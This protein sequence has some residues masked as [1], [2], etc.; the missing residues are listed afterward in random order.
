MWKTHWGLEK[1]PF[2][3][4]DAL[5]VSLPAHD[6]AVARLIHSIETQER[7]AFLTAGAGLGKSTVLRR[8]F[9]ETQSPR[10]RFVLA[11][12][13]RDGTVLFAHLAERFAERVGREPSRLA[14]WRALERAIRLASIQGTHVILGIDDCQLADSDGRRDLEA[15]TRMGSGQNTRLTV[16]Q[17][18]RRTRGNRDDRWAVAIGLE[19]LT[20][21][22]A[23]AFLATKLAGAGCR[24]SPFTPRAVT[25]LHC[26]GAGV[27]RRLQQLATRCLMVGAS[28][29]LL[30]IRP[31]LVDGLAEEISGQAP[32]ALGAA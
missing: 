11:S 28:R 18:G 20:R 19:S 21:S 13:P 30:V 7:R 9:A 29:G 5:Y 3:E 16:I 10:R 1:E 25:R 6:E 22:E 26:L 12:C 32:G 15:L 2:A 27:P 31:E 24:Q 17:C 8:A 14:S 4:S 23:D